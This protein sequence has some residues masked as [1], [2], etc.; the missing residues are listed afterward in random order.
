MAFGA[1][2]TKTIGTD[3]RDYSTI[4][5]WEDDL[6][7]GTTAANDAT[8]YSSGD[9]ALGECYADSD[10]DET[11]LIN[12]G[13]TVPL[14]S[15]TLSVASGQRHNGTAN[16]G[17]R[18][19]IS[20]NSRILALDNVNRL[21]GIEWLEWDC[22]S[23]ISSGSASWLRIFAGDDNFI[24]NMIL[25]EFTGTAGVSGLIITGTTNRSSVLNNI[26]YDGV[27]TNDSTVANGIDVIGGAGPGAINYIYN[28]TVHNIRQ[29]TGSGSANCLVIDV[30]NANKHIKNNICTDADSTSGTTKDIN[31]AGTTIDDSNNASSD[32][33]ANDGG[34]ADHIENIV[35]ADQFISTTLGSENLLLKSGADVIDAGVDLGT[36]VGVNIDITGR[37]RDAEGDV[38]DIGADEFVGVAV[39]AG[40]I[41]IIN[42]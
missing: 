8:A 38:W 26:I 21:Q 34:G 5:L 42:N 9:D 27:S 30:N 35:I 36:T 20:A 39:A 14:T 12:G 31:Y 40:Q 29:P 2:L 13:T 15:V 19:L 11:V 3:S 17:A 28:N 6:D 37:D 7:D 41:I 1:V 33:T 16:T 10:F 4:T 23:K 24:R 18:G 25:H 22:N 32:A